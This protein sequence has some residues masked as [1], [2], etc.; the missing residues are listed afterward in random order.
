LSNAPATTDCAWSAFGKLTLRWRARRAASLP[1]PDEPARGLL[2][3]R[4]RE[5]PELL[6]ESEGWRFAPRR[7]RR[8]LG[9]G[10]AAPTLMLKVLPPTCCDT[11]L[12]P[13]EPASDAAD[14]PPVVPVA[15]VA[16][17]LPGA[18]AAGAELVLCAAALRCAGA[19]VPWGGR[20]GAV[21]GSVGPVLGRWSTMIGR[22][23][24]WSACCL[25]HARGSTSSGGG[26]ALPRAVVVIGSRCCCGWRWRSCWLPGSWP[27]PP[28]AC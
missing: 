21:A 14:G 13:A 6:L 22:C 5:S 8:L 15:A 17:V 2:P 9:W 25:C 12:P 23:A 27:A 16:D 24:G 18:R 26:W 28:T 1:A 11:A 19:R 20:A 4:G 10:W 3:P 7:P